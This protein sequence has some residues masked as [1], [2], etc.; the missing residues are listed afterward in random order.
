MDTLEKEKRIA[1]WALR[2]LAAICVIY[3]IGQVD[4]LFP[5]QIPEKFSMDF[6][7]FTKILTVGAGFYIFS[8]YLRI[9]G[10]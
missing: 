1:V 8:V 4:L 2:F 3:V 9:K 5:E 7:L 6:W 10:W